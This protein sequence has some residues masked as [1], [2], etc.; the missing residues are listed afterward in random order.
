MQRETSVCMDWRAELRF[1]TRL[2]SE[3]GLFTAHTLA[4]DSAKEVEKAKAFQ[5]RF[6]ALHQEVTRHDPAWG[7]VDQVK[8]AT[9]GLIEFHKDLLSDEL[10]Y[11]LATNVPPGFYDHLL[12]EEMGFLKTAEWIEAGCFPPD[13]ELARFENILWLN[14]DADIDSLDAM[15]D[16]AEKGDKVPH[17]FRSYNQQFMENFD[18]LYQKA[19]ILQRYLRVFRVP[20][21]NQMEALSE[22]GHFLMHDFVR[23]LHYLAEEIREQQPMS[24]LVTTLPDHIA[25]EGAYYIAHTPISRH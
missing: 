20:L 11:K 23:Y 15:T 17:G 19:L 9:Q 7:L 25:R 22:D 24:A 1:W 21:G 13:P 3:H 5:R 12:R 8:A 10:R 2:F 18:A 16:P 6:E 14:M 4:P